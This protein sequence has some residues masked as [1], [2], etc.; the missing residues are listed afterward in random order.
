MNPRPPSNNVLMISQRPKT[1]LILGLLMIV[2]LGTLGYEVFEQNKNITNFKQQQ[3]KVLGYITNQCYQ[4]EAQQKQPPANQTL[5][6]PDWYRDIINNGSND[7]TLNRCLAYAKNQAR[8]LGPAPEPLLKSTILK[9]EKF[10]PDLTLPAERNARLYQQQYI[11]ELKILHS[12]CNDQRKVDMEAVPNAES[13]KQAQQ[14]SAPVW[15]KWRQ[16]QANASAQARKNL[17][18]KGIFKPKWSHQL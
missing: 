11:N 15:Q 1:T 2:G 13:F 5:I 10:I 9:I 18:K 6:L 12:A 4:F 17:E 7:R 16:C 14:N 8:N 3:S